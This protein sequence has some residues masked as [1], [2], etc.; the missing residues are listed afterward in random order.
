M[1][2]EWPARQWACGAHI[3]HALSCG[4]QLFRMGRV[5]SL[6]MKQFTLSMSLAAAALFAVPAT[7]FAQAPPAGDHH[8][9]P[10]GAHRMGPEA[11][12]EFLTEKLGLD[13]NQ[14]AQ[15]KAI[16][17]KYHPQVK[18]LMAKGRENLT[19]ADKAALRDLRK[20]QAAEMRP[21]LTPEQQEKLK[22][23]RRE[24]RHEGK[25]GASKPAAQ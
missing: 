16:F 9:R 20:A 13:A 25:H 4:L 24:G 2:C 10:E 3:L 7:T 11:R 22:E 21:V 15:I 17:T 1:K 18:A 14:Q 23:L 8:Q 6:T 12:L 5:G 19:D